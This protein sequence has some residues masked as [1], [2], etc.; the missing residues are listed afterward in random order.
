[1][2]DGKSRPLGGAYIT[3]IYTIKLGVGDLLSL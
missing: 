1:M 2:R 3:H